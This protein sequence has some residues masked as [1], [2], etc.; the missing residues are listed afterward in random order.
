MTM[1]NK[2][3]DNAIAQGHATTIVTKGTMWRTKFHIMSIIH[4]KSLILNK[5][6]NMIV[7][8]NNNN[9]NNNNSSQVIASRTNIMVMESMEGDMDVHSHLQTVATTTTT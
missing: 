8:N 5:N 9:N 7:N 2:A 1:V 3:I 4:A 6:T